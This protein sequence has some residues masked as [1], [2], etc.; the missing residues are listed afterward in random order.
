MTKFVCKEC[1]YKIE[2]ESRPRKCPYCS[3]ESIEEEKNAEELIEEVK[4]ILD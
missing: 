1:G 3:K 4:K 2:T